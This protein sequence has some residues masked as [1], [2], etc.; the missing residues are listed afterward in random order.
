MVFP[1]G[2]AHCTAKILVA[3]RQRRRAGSR[4]GRGNGQCLV[5][6]VV[7]SITVELIGARLGGDVQIAAGAA[8]RFAVAGRLE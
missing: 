4:K 7:I 2:A 1:D 8:A 5:A 3:Q 6:V